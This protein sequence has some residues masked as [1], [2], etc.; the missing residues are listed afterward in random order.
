MILRFVFTLFCATDTGYNPTPRTYMVWS[1]MSI[2]MKH[3]ALINGHSLLSRGKH[4]SCIRATHLTRPAV[5]S[6]AHTNN[7]CQYTY[8]INI[9]L[10]FYVQCFMSTV[11]SSFHP[12]LSAPA[13]V[14]W[15]QFRVQMFPLYSWILFFYIHFQDNMQS[16]LA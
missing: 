5:V 6:N 10:F 12:E 7:R 2:T 15:L 1:P 9:L 3:A 11:L 8:F 13:I 14:V 16:S 4:V